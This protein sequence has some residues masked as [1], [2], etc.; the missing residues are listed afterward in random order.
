MG[1]N[2]TQAMYKLENGLAIAFW[3]DASFERRGPL[4]RSLIQKI[5]RDFLGRELGER[6]R[7]VG[8]DEAPLPLQPD[9][10]VAQIAVHGLLLRR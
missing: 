4:A 5:G 1:A 10:G 8:P 7:E 2:F 9:P 6:R 3:A